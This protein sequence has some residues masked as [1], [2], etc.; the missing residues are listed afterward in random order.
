MPELGDAY[1]FRSSLVDALI[2]DLLGP[3]S[4]TE[5]LS[6]PPITR[7]ICGILYPQPAA[8]KGVSGGVDA[9]DDI[10]E[11]DDY[12]ES[13]VPDP[14]VAMANVKYPSSVGLTFAVDTHA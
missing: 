2:R 11:P 8:A 10:D 1:A 12:D 14:P 7:Y 6:D 13:A 4:P 5:T 3:S 9:A